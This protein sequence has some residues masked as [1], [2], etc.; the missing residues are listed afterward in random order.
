MK[1]M[2]KYAIIGETVAEFMRQ[3]KPG[4]WLTETQDAANK[5]QRQLG[6]AALRENCRVRCE[7]MPAIRN[8]DTV[9][10]VLIAEMHD[11]P[12]TTRGQERLRSTTSTAR[13]ADART[14][15]PT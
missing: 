1:K 7:T 12:P 13:H 14:S 2:S 11:E 5:M 15:T 8:G 6:A 3:K 9:V 10:F 4:M